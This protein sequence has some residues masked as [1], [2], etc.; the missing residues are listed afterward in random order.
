MVNPRRLSALVALCC[1]AGCAAPVDAPNI[2]LIVADDLGYEVLRANGGTSYETPNLDALA[3]GGM[4]FTRCYSAPL[5]TLSVV[6]LLT[7]RYSFRNYTGWGMLSPSEHTVVHDLRDGGYRTAVFGK[8]QLLRG[9][10][11]GQRGSF[12]MEAGFD[13][14][15]VWGLRGR[16]NRYKSPRVEETGRPPVSLE[17]EYGPDV[18]ADRA[19]DFIERHRDEPFF[20]FYPMVLTHAPCQPTPDDAEYAEFD[21][22]VA[23]PNTDDPRYYASNVAYA[24]A[25]VGRLVQQLDRLGLR[26]NTLLLFTADNGTSRRI[27]SSMGERQ[28]AGGKGHTTSAG[29][30]VPLMANWPGRIPP[31][32]TNDDLVGFTDFLPTL[33]TVAG[34]DLPD[35]GDGLSFHPRILD[36]AP[37]TVRAWLLGDYPGRDAA[38]T[39]RRYVHDGTWKLY[40]DGRFLC[41]ATDPEEKLPVTDEEL[42]AADRELKASFQHVLKRI[43]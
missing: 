32:G 33:L 34:I 26:Q 29:T 7:G 13:E 42:T 39:P 10:T 4:R 8:W 3:R 9:R 35:D 37:D 25:L 30:H 24:D 18:F 11:R 14:Y 2:V 16:G 21:P 15:C 1:L 31:G 40:D 5:G 43:E 22:A 19:E 41:M 12:P 28:V 38:S 6:Q 36:S 20:L 23:G 27:V 17:G